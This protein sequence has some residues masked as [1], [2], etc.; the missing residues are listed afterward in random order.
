MR[1]RILLILVILAGLLPACTPSGAAVLPAENPAATQT[2]NAFLADIVAQAMAASPSPTSPPPTVTPIPSPT[3]AP[4]KIPGSPDTVVLDRLPQYRLDVEFNYSERYGV[5]SEEIVYTNRSGDAIPSLRLMVELAAYK[6]LFS[7]TG[8]WWQD[9]QKIENATWENIQVNI[10]L[11]NALMPGQSLGLKLAYEFH[12]PSQSAVAG[13]RPIPLGYTSRQANLVD[14]FPFIPPYRS[15]K[16]WLAHPP[17]YYGEH[18]V[19]DLADFEVNLRLTDARDDLVVAASAAPQKD[20]QWLRYKH[21]RARGF[22]FS[23]GHEYVAET[24]Q[25]GKV[26]VTSYYF[27]LN[28]KAGKQ[29]LKTT[30]EALKLYQDLFGPYPHETLAVVEAD[31]FD[32]MEYDGLY[33]LSRAFYNTFTGTQEDY[34]VAIAAHE[35]SHQWWYGVVA[36]DQANEPWLDEALSTYCERLFY[37]KYYPEALDWWWYYRINYYHPQGW[38][39]TSVYNPQ[40]TLQ[41]YQDY[42]NAVYLNGAHFFEDLRTLMGDQAFFAFLKDYATK[43]AGQVVLSEDFFALLGQHTQADLTPLLKQYFSTRQ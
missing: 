30:V 13:D 22:A 3:P 31:F 6:E 2:A 35:T 14:W 17:S 33:F 5:V 16:G 27:P 26:A 7:F 25:V 10:P 34:L 43:F 21:E 8:L 20:G 1:F 32:G 12:L 37:E 24:I 11:E 41:T 9:G 38:V 40:G 15:G 42:R 29:A 28:V 18:L 36:S 23:I 39:D 19:Y 4:S